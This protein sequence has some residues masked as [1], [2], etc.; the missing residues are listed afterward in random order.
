MLLFVRSFFSSRTNLFCE[1]FVEIDILFS[2]LLSRRAIGTHASA[3]AILVDHEYVERPR[4]VWHV[5][6]K[7]MRVTLLLRKERRRHANNE[8]REAKS[9]RG[10]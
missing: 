9:L 8:C 1:D 6:P 7:A 4:P 3:A 2:L 5:C 10:K